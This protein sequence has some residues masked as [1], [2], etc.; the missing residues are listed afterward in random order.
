MDVEEGGE[1]GSIHGVSFA[2]FS[3]DR[4]VDADRARE[5]VVLLRRV[6]H[7]RVGAELRGQRVLTRDDPMHVRVVELEGRREPS[8]RAPVAGVGVGPGGA[9]A[10]RRASVCALLG[11]S[12]G[13]SNVR[14]APPPASASTVCV[15]VSSMSAQ[16]RA[17]GGSAG[18]SVLIVTARNV[19]FDGPP[20]SVIVTVLG[21][22][23][24]R[25]G[26]SESARSGGPGGGVF[27]L[28]VNRAE[29][30]AMAIPTHGGLAFSL[31]FALSSPP[32]MKACG[33][34]GSP[35]VRSRRLWTRTRNDVLVLAR[36]PARHPR[37]CTPRPRR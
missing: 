16:F 20:L 8:L 1:F 6:V 12:G 19:G 18:E 28:S 22:T 35:V 33:A 27:F 24:A 11:L 15:L 14:F 2:S 13:T 7:V 37:T 17:T 36:E 25:S 31:L 5:G 32:Q 26:S 9:I 10:C 3:F 29:V 23:P 34:A 21:Q 30:P 4:H